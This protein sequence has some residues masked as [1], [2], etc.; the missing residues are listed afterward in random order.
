MEKLPSFPCLLPRVPKWLG[1][2][3]LDSMKW[4]KGIFGNY[5][6]K[7]VYAG[8]VTQYKPKAILSALNRQRQEDCPRFEASSGYSASFKPIGLPTPSQNMQGPGLCI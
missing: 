8:V 6:Q 7:V 1:G 5:L 4:F 2:P 3:D